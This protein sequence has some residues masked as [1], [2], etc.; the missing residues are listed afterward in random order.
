MARKIDLDK[1]IWEGWTVSDFIED[2]EPSLDLIMGGGSYIEIKTERELNNWC[3]SNQPYYKQH[4]PEV[5]QY[6][7]QKY[8]I[9]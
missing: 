1:H 9:R 2:L 3:I 4:I 8:N 6:F 7:K 5:V